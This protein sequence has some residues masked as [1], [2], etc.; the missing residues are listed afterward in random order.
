[1]KNYWIKYVALC[2]GWGLL[3]AACCDDIKTFSFR[4]VDIEVEAQDNWIGAAARDSVLFEQFSISMA[5]VTTDPVQLASTPS[6]VQ[7]AYAFSRCPS[8]D[9][10]V[11]EITTKSIEIRTLFPFNDDLGPGSIMPLVNRVDD[12]YHYYDEVSPVWEYHDNFMFDAE[13][14]ETRKQR[15]LVEIKL[16]DGTI[17][18]DT[19]LAI[20]LIP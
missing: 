13:P 6:F 1:M 16:E 12:L 17:L 4:L 5:F 20:V 19:T 15:F 3:A 11:P 2:L 10:Y 9:H 7:K 18:R 8:W 14:S